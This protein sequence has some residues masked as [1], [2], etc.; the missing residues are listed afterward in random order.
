MTDKFTLEEI[1]VA[2]SLHK[3][4][5]SGVPIAWVWDWNSESEGARESFI[6]Q[7]RTVIAKIQK[8][9]LDNDLVHKREMEAL[10]QDKELAKEYPEKGLSSFEGG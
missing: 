2:K 6:Y 3:M 7:A 9:R 4:M 1:E 5:K 10:E 8:A